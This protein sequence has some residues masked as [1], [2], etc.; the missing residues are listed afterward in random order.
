MLVNKYKLGQEVE[1]FFD[2]RFTLGRIIGMNIVDNKIEYEVAIEP[3]NIDI[4]KF[5]SFRKTGIIKRFENG[6]RLPKHM[7]KENKTYDNTESEEKIKKI[8]GADPISAVRVLKIELEEDKVILYY[9]NKGEFK[10][11]LIVSKCH[12]DDTFNED[13]GIMACVIKCQIEVLKRILRNI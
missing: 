13:K 3:I 2:K 12:P 7:C 9:T 11:K 8:F 4:N 10:P 6:I 1:V 5:G